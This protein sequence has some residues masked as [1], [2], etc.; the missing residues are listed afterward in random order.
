MLPLV[1][2]QNESCRLF[3]YHCIK[4]LEQFLA[5][6]AAQPKYSVWENF[7]LAPTA[8]LHRSFVKSI[9]PH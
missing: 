6:F 5:K 7:V 9:L 4:K 2:I 3:L 1:I 8:S